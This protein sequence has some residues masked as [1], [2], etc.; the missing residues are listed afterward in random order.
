VRH[1]GGLLVL[2]AVGMFAPGCVVRSG[3]YAFA[4]DT[5]TGEAFNEGWGGYLEGEVRTPRYWDFVNVAWGLG[6]EQGVH[7]GTVH[8]STEDATF[9]YPQTTDKVDASMY[10]TR[11]TARVYPLKSFPLWREGWRLAPYGGIGAGCFWGDVEINQ[12]GPF[13]GLDVNGG[14][15]YGLNRT[16]DNFFGTFWSWS[17]GL[18]LLIP[19]TE[20][21]SRGWD[22][23]DWDTPTGPSGPMFVIEYR[24]DQ[25]KRDG[26]WNFDAGQILFGIGLSW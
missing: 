11:V 13:L 6:L 17:F 26:I 9:Y 25:N 20:V 1:A 4:K 5:R 2:I 24:Q 8:Y 18:E 3:N 12:R 16:S 22:W 21:A 15:H 23:D 19:N 10:D 7:G 14:A